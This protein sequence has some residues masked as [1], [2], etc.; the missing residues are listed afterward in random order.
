VFQTVRLKTMP[1]EF[2]VQVGQKYMPFQIAGYANSIHSH[3]I[4]S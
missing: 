3:L 2:A 4:Y 1:G